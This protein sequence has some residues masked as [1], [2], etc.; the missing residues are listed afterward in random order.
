M[1]LLEVNFSGA[2]SSSKPTKPPGHRTKDSGT[3]SRQHVSHLPSGG[4]AP[5]LPDG[6]LLG[7]RR[8]VEP[9]QRRQHCPGDARSNFRTQG[10]RTGA[11]GE[12]WPAWPRLTAGEVAAQQSSGPPAGTRLGPHPRAPLGTLGTEPGGR[13]G[14]GTRPHSSRPTGRLGEA[15]DPPDGGRLKKMI[16]LSFIQQILESCLHRIF[17]SI[18]EEGR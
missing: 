13:T 2:S 12:L 10:F 5:G 3:Q 1:D 4:A 17:I 8:P 16:F 11:S 15:P 14:L 7:R 6:Q 9:L 18:S